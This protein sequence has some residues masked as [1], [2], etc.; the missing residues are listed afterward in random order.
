MRAVIQRV[1]QA[2]IL[3]GDSVVATIGFGLLIF[4][5]IH[6]DDT[7]K[8][9]DF[10]LHKLLKLR[11]FSNETKNINKSIEDVGGELL[12]VSQFTLY[13]N[14]TKGNRPSFIHA[15]PPEQAECF[16]E[17]FVREAKKRYSLIVKTVCKKGISYIK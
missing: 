5:G 12:L 10:I 17:D 14:C 1:D 6:K 11:L 3:A 9:R 15:M 2:S 8:D 4:V 13:A 7:E 16:Y